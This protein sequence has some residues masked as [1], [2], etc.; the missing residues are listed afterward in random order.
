MKKRLITILTVI[1][2][3]V[4]SGC[5]N[6]SRGSGN[7]NSQDGKNNGNSQDSAKT[8]TEKVKSLQNEMKRYSQNSNTLSPKEVNDISTSCIKALKEVLSAKESIKATEKDLLGGEAS[9]YIK[10]GKEISVGDT[11]YRFAEFGHTKDADGAITN[12]FLQ[13]VGGKKEPLVMEVVKL[14]S[15]ASFIEKLLNYDLVKSESSYYAVVFSKFN[16]AESSLVKLYGFHLESRKLLPF[17]FG[18][19]GYYK[20]WELDNSS[21][22]GV[23]N[24]R[25]V[26]GASDYNFAVDNKLAKVEA[27]DNNG[28][29][30]SVVKFSIPKN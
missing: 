13:E 7:S 4:L 9:F 23:Y 6:N 25:Y 10:F 21:T 5:S 8:Y 15:N 28:R 2:L 24:I 30:I 3:L 20:G 19:M 22:N 18:C 1:C 14:T 17:K 26:S 16:G 27:L 12:L 11:K 29:V